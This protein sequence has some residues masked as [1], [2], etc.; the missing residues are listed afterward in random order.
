MAGFNINC[1]EPFD[2]AT[3]QFINQK[4]EYNVN[5]L[6]GCKAD[7]AASE[8]CPVNGCGISRVGTLESAVRESVN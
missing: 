5:T 8:K 1:V 7:G 6:C 2:Y 4:D 3:R